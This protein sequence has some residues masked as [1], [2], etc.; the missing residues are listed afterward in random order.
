MSKAFG[1]WL[2]SE[3]DARDWG[4]TEASRQFGVRHGLIRHW[5]NGDRNPNAESLSKIALGLQLPA[6]TVFEAAGK[7]PPGDAPDP[8]SNYS[9]MRGLIDAIDWDVHEEWMLGL[10]PTLR[11][12]AKRQA[13]EDAA[14]DAEIAERGE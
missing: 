8:N 12:Y 6:A 7:L 13:A 5:L 2:Q 14:V 9:K 4:V 10:L 3:I 11:S 1:D